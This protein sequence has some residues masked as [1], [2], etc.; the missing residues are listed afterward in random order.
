MCIYP[1]D[2]PF[3][4]EQGDHHNGEG[5]ICVTSDTFQGNTVDCVCFR[6]EVVDRRRSFFRCVWMTRRRL[7]AWVPRER[8]IEFSQA[9]SVV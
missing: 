5:A 2:S 8:R 1:S 3:G 9:I 6:I 7:R 4:L